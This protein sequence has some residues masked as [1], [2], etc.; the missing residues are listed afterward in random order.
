MRPT[1]FPLTVV[2]PSY[3]RPESAIRAIRSLQQQDEDFELL[4]VDN[5]C[6]S[7]LRDA[8]DTVNDGARIKA[9]WIPEPQLG[10]HHARHA[11]A[12]RATS[13]L[14]AFA[15]DDATFAPGWARAYVEAFAE[16]PQMVA[17][18]GP[19]SA[20]WEA[21]PPGWLK[22]WVQGQ[23]S[24]FQYG[25]RDLGG[26]VRIGSSELFWGGNMVIRREVL[27][28]SGGFNPDSIGDR[29]IGDGETG[30]FD[31]LQA[32]GAVFGYIPAARANHHIPAAR[33]NVEFL[34]RRMRNEGASEA[35]GLLRDHR[36]GSSLRFASMGASCLLAAATAWLVALPFRAGRG[37]LALGVQLRAE[38]LVG[39]VAYAYA[40]LGDVELRRLILRDNWLTT[41]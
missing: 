32:Q 14:I 34:R 26:D 1:A 29:S 4:V 11:G 27:F 38:R 12:R 33:M 3:A 41:P 8:I 16:H 15:D 5:A 24:C 36:D 10:L 22:Q 40:A 9:T 30:L 18:S 20:A 35:Y 25:V 37:A 21:P 2:V 28:A 31:R 23:R 6:S 39:R 17:A 19:L 7:A 13:D